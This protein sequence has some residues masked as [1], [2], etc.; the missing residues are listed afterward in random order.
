[1]EGEE[2]RGSC[3][4]EI[5]QYTQLTKGKE[6]SNKGFLGRERAGHRGPKVTDLD[7]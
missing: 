1:M 5:P 3:G 2:T 6:I 7:V 4:W